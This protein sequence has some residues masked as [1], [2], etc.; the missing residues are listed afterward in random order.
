MQHLV[1]CLYF[2]LIFTRSNFVLFLFK[3]DDTSSNTNDN[4]T[5]SKRNKSNDRK[6]RN[7]TV[8]TFLYCLV[9][10]IGNFID[11]VFLLFASL[12]NLD[13]YAKYGFINVTGNILLFASHS[14]HFFLS[15]RFNIVFR[16]R[17]KE[18]FKK[19]FW[20]QYFHII[21]TLVYRSILIWVFFITNRL[22]I[23]VKNI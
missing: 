15:Y 20:N 6:E 12:A 8:L 17:F 7:F 13:I 11:D 14:V 9:Y 3:A 2:L 1:I 4:L 22:F 21:N 19:I 16:K 5:S 23:F 10:F 18:L